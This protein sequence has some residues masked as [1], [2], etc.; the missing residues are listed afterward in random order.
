MRPKRPETRS[1]SSKLRP[2]RPRKKAAKL[3]RPARAPYTE[4]RRFF[5][6]S[7]LA[8]DGDLEGLSRA[9]LAYAAVFPEDANCV[10]G[11]VQ[12]RC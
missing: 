11:A 8:Q 1:Q 2:A 7:E 5:E 9:Y 6:V 12:P 10:A 3:L 4:I